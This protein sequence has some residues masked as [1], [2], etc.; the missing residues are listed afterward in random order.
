M[1]KINISKQ[2]YFVKLCNLSKDCVCENLNYEFLVYG[3][4]SINLIVLSTTYEIVLR[5]MMCTNCKRIVDYQLFWIVF[6]AFFSWRINIIWYWY[7][8]QHYVILLVYFLLNIF[9]RLVLKVIYNWQ[10]T[11][12]MFDISSKVVNWL[13]MD[14]VITLTL[15][16]MFQTW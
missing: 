11:D 2:D 15:N 9:F 1:I 6:V 14:V 8:M 12:V 4:H 5:K 7:V 13:D 3:I 10:W 16:I